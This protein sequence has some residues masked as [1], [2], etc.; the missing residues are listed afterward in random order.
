MKH[1]GHAQKYR[2]PT[3]E[4]EIQPEELDNIAQTVAAGLVTPA[5][6]LHA[7]QSQQGIGMAAPTTP[8]L[9]NPS[10]KRQREEMEDEQ[11]LKRQDTTES[12]RKSA[13][14]REA[15]EVEEEA[16][17]RQKAGESS[18]G[19]PEGVEVHSQTNKAS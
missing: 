19:K 4:A 2:Q 5:P 12:P 10:T 3:L 1:G 6:G 18:E 7:G 15:A 16:E 14:K 13:E 8:A 11:V 17:K 9:P